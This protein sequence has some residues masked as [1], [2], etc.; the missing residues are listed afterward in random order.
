MLFIHCDYFFYSATKPTKVAEKISEECKSCAVKDVLVVFITVEKI[1][2][3]N[4]EEVAFRGVKEIVEMFNRLGV[5]GLVLFPFVHLSEE[6]G[7][8]EI[9]RKIIE[10][11]YN[12]L[13]NLNYT[14]YKAPFGWEKIFSLTS[15]G[16]PL[17][18]SLRIIRL[19]KS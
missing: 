16:H 18:E 11:M 19:S 13:K 17:A 6:A 4:Y 2:E 12:Q 9:A 10:E 15:K 8:P 3:K 1:D 7:K 5:K 14:V